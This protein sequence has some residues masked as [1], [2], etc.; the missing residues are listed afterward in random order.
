MPMNVYYVPIDIEDKR[1]CCQCGKKAKLVEIFSGKFFCNECPVK[2]VN[3]V[4]MRQ[5]FHRR[6]NSKK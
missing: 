6:F 4:K 1:V 2:M 5:H 3:N